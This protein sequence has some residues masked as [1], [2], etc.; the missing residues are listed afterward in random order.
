MVAKR[1]RNIGGPILAVAVAPLLVDCGAGMPGVPGAPGGCEV[2][3]ANPQAIMSANFGLD[4]SIEGKLKAADL[5]EVWNTKMKEYQGLTPPD[6]A[7]GVLQDVHWSEGLLG[8]FPTYALGNLVASQLWEKIEAVI[9]DVTKKIESAQFDP[10]LNW[11]REN[12]H[13]FGTKF[14][15]MELLERITGSGLA[16]EPYLRYLRTKFGEIYG[17]S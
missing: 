16:A 11:L 12:V 10:L 15:P 6:D 1:W 14:E 17:I 2:D 13:Q 8:Y 5:P 9:P 3:L 7:Q 4:A